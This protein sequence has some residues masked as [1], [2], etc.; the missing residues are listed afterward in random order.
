M[1]S[2]ALLTGIKSIL[3]SVGT[4]N[5]FIW[6][7]FSKLL[8]MIMENPLIALPVLFAVLA[9]SISVVIKVIRKFGVKGKR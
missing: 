6:S 3:E 7:L 4:A 1:E 9:G 8:T 5:T 2:S